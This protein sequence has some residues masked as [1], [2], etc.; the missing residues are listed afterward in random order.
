[1]RNAIELVDKTAKII[2]SFSE[3][4]MLRVSLIGEAISRL[5]FEDPITGIW[6]NEPRPISTYQ[7]H[8][9]SSMEIDEYISPVDQI[10][11]R[12]LWDRGYNGSSM[13]IA[14][15]DT[16]V[17]S[18]HPDL[19]VA[20]YASF[21]EVDT[22]PTDLIGHGT[23]AASIAAGNGN[24]SE[25]LYSGIAPG[26]TILSG[27]VTLGG[28]FASPSWIVSGIEWASSRGADIILLPFN[29]FG[30]P[31]DAVSIAVE[32][33]TRKG[34][35]VVAASGDDGPDYLTIM[36]PGGS[37][38]VLTVGAYD[39]EKQRVPDFSGRGPSLSMLTKPD[40]VAPGVGIVGAKA[41]AGLA[42]LGFGD[43]NLGDL[44][45][46][47]GLG[48]LL[49]GGLGDDLDDDYV[50]A[51]S[52]TASAAVVAGAAAILMEAFDRATP[53]VISNVLRDTAISIEEGA[54]DG[55]AGVIDLK[56]AFEYLSTRQTP[57]SPHNRTTGT[58]LF[59]L[60]V[61]TTSGYDASTLMLMSSFGTNV[62]ALDTREGT[63]GGIHMLMG[64]FALRWNDRDSTNLMEFDIKRE[65]HMVNLGTGDYGYSRQI[66]ILSY[67]DEVYVTLL[68]ESYNLTEYSSNPLTGIKVTPYILNLGR[69]PIENVSLFLS[70]SLD[71]YM[72]GNDDH[73]KYSLNNDEIFVYS[74]NEELDNFYFGMNASRPMDA[75]EVGNSSDI[76]SHISNDNLTG[77]TTFDG[78]VGLGMKWNFGTVEHNNPVNVTIATG[79][80]ENRTLLDESIE[81][82]WTVTPLTTEQYDTDLIVVEADIPRV[83][84]MG[85]SY[86]SRAVIMNIGP[87]PSTMSAVLV[88]AKT[89]DNGTSLYSRIESFDDVQPFQAHVVE[90]EWS[91]EKGGIN[92]AAWVVSSGID[93]ALGLFTQV[94]LLPN[95]DS[96]LGILDSVFPLLDDFLLRDLFVIEPIYSASVFPR[97]LPFAPFDIRFPADFGLYTVLVSTTIPLGN[98][99]VTK[100]GNAS[101]WGDVELP[102]RDSVEGF[103]N[104]SMFLMAP[105]ITIDG[106]HSCEYMLHTDAG[107]TTNITLE[108]E[109]QYPRAMFLLDG[110]HGGGLSFFGGIDT[111]STED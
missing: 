29:T 55:G 60:G 46:L 14:V 51:D 58:P 56:A 96:I 50:I 32:E 62:I 107:W 109:L 67:D 30:A 42:S 90:T 24:R 5:A 48:G 69:H 82:M 70:Y 38:E 103:Y 61:V 106:F 3:L 49:G 73:G 39:Y 71:L 1:A 98:L 101:D 97:I 22:L 20:A 54:N 108:R 13:V 84:R 4:N 110:S 11:A 87:N 31:G 78:S 92:T 35:L 83:A 88:I 63:S 72:D 21:V 26:A 59:A 99:T 37:A 25:G 19:N 93:Q 43:I 66:G 45:D 15:L 105:P 81:A 75:F 23:Y 28:L 80:A 12:N 27:K 53:I 52:T 10:G 74:V 86:Q 36:S 7:E 76:S 6:A 40:L 64:M 47:G 91:P 8:S 68:V 2:E 18:F 16:G 33:A 95:V 94:S 17:D 111:G 77:A 102:H 34:I 57:I 44:G 104:F 41:G 79:F 89:D 65:L 9:I 85:E 100:H